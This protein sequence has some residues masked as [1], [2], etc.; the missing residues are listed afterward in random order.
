MALKVGELF[1]T[2]GLDDSAFGKGLDSAQKSF[3]NLSAMLA[4]TGAALSLAVTVP[5]VALGKQILNAGTSFQTGMSEV[6][7]ISGATG[8][9]LDAL[10]RKAREMGATTKFSASQS[11]EALKYMA[12]AGWNTEK[13]LGGIEGIMNLAAAEGG[14]LGSVADIVTDALTAFGL[15]AQDSTQFADVLAAASSASNT[16][17]TLLGGSF[18]YAAATA[19][20][21]GYTAEDVAISLGLMANAGIKGEMAGTQLRNIMAGLASPTKQQTKALKQ[22][23]VSA[24]DSDGNMRPL[25]ET[26]SDLRTGFAELTDSQ[27]AQY[28]ET[29]AGKEGMSGLLALV[30]ASDED[31][32]RLTQSIYHSGG[33]AA[34]MA[35][36]MQ[37][38]LGGDWTTLTSGL[39]GAMIGMFDSVQ[40]TLRGFV[41]RLSA[42]VSWF[43][44][45]DAGV[46]RSIVVFG[47]FAA[48]TG[49]LLVGLSGLFKV[50][51]R[52]TGALSF[53]TGPV[54]L[55]AAGLVILYKACKP[56]QN[57]VKKM[58]QF[59]KTFF[60]MLGDGKDTL[61]A[62]K[63]ALVMA[64]GG[65][66]YQQVMGALSAIQAGW[67]RTVKWIADTGEGVRDALSA[68]LPVLDNLD[69]AI[70][71]AEQA[72][73]I[74][75]LIEGVQMTRRQMLDSGA[76]LGL[77]EV[78]ALGE[79][80]DP[81]LHNAVMRT[82]EGEPGTV[83]E[84][85][86]KGYRVKD[87]IIRYAMVKVAAE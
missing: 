37:D 28:A 69:R 61:T 71:A 43:N 73:D 81:E 14:D 20:A 29:L 8:A 86:Q 74:G 12:M 65:D 83:L 7:A 34:K 55:A 13:M 31:F 39:E 18:K 21:L 6:S 40:E 26:V 52:S 57:A 80:F 36:I 87:K 58:G 32:A 45:L 60:G 79:K 59:F 38:N 76:K 64:F 15:A 77:Q 62:I 17:V 11:A 66:A 44:G 35:A 25:N 63:T 49:P 67:G 3:S 54:G 16:S 46:M 41:Q 33:A 51:A 24:V 1:A 50:L 56:V 42:A 68:M 10:T 4:K 48:A 53:L 72:P 9:E 70:A 23:G 22:L 75:K 47:A 2:I 30:G 85:F 78:P 84:V 27:R 82:E 5:L 19:G